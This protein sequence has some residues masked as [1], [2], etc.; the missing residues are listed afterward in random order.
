M[1]LEEEITKEKIMKVIKALTLLAFFAV[2]TQGQ[3]AI[4]ASG[5]AKA[6]I[7]EIA[8][9]STDSDRLK[10]LEKLHGYAPV[11]KQDVADLLNAIRDKSI[12]AQTVSKTL[13]NTSN[14][15]LI[16]VFASALN[17]SDIE[18]QIASARVLGKMKAAEALPD[19]IGKFK[20]LPAS[21]V[22]SGNEDRSALA[23]KAR[24][25]RH[26]AE[27]MGV[28]GDASAVPVLI[29]RPEFYFLEFGEAPL[30]MIGAPALPTLL[31]VGNSRDD[32]RKEKVCVIIGA[33]KDQSAVP[34]LKA[35]LSDAN[36]DIMV[37][38][39]SFIALSKMGVTGIESDAQALLTDK[40]KQSRL[41]ALYW[42]MKYDKAGYSAKLVEFLSDSDWYVRATAA[43][44][45][46]ELKVTAAA[47]RLTELLN[48]KNA[49]VQRNALFALEKLGNVKAVFTVLDDRR[50]Q[51]SI[52]YQGKAYQA[53]ISDVTL[54]REARQGIR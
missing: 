43:N 49:H 6:L 11:D 7:G 25:G 46:G 36:A 28:I 10:S 35:A 42:M 19:L 32:Q 3:A 9:A 30:A 4:A 29:E 41:A 23:S 37:R 45:A 31:K 47:Q 1:I 24:L 21:F 13:M 51:A 18:V 14:R 16:P 15:D 54:V 2:L 38:T 22:P 44:Y 20:Q 53:T 40:N 39:S 12:S 33:I 27:A 34:T 48:D 8:G 5:S 26:L 17:D 52:A 50:V